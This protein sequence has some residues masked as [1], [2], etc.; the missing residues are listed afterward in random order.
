[1]ENQ[2]VKNWYLPLIKGIIM[3]V[4]ALMIFNSPEESL[5]AWVV[6][7]GI[8]FIL[9]GIVFMIQGFSARGTLDN[10]GWRVFEGVV[11]ILVGF[12]LIANPAITAAILPFIIGLWGAF[13]GI[14]LFID[15]FAEKG[16]R[17]IKLI[18]GIVIFLFSLIVIFNP[19]FAGMTIAIWFGIILFCAGLYNV[20]FSFA[21]KRAK[22]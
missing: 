13:Y 19:L 18:S 15:A 12:V 20:F 17:G 7:I 9:S 16:G 1:M 8:G 2:N 3:I 22:S 5:L 11:D 10:W 6:Y 21:L 14:M 4:L